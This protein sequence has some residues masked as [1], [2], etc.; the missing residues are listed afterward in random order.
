[1]RAQLDHLDAPVLGVV[2]NCT[3]PSAGYYGYG[4]RAREPIASA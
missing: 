2:V 4:Y 1:L 3:E